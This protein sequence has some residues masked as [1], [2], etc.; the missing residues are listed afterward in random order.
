MPSLVQS[1]KKRNG[2]IATNKFKLR[3]CFNKALLKCL[4]ISIGLVILMLLVV[5][6]TLN[7]NEALVNVWETSSNKSKENFRNIKASFFDESM[8]E[9]E[10]VQGSLDSFT[11]NV[12]SDFFPNY[13]MNQHT[14]SPLASICEGLKY[15]N[16]FYYHVSDKFITEDLVKVRREVL[17]WGDKDITK[18]ITKN[19]KSGLTDKQIVD[20]FWFE[21]GASPVWLESENCYVA[22]SRIISAGL[23]RIHGT[24]SLVKAR[25]FDKNWN[26]IEGKRIPY[27]DVIIPENFEEKLAKF[28]IPMNAT[29]CQEFDKG[30]ELYENCIKESMAKYQSDQKKKE[31][32]IDKYFITYPRVLKFKFNFIDKFNGPEDPRVILKSDRSGEEPILIFN[33]DEG[34]GR[35]IYSLL[36]HRKRETLLEYKIEG[37][38]LKKVEKNWAPFF[39]PSYEKKNILS[40]N[41]IN[42]VYSFIPLEILQC[43]LDDGNCRKIFSGRA[44]GLDDNNKFN[45]LRGGTQF[46]PVPNIFPGHEGKNIW[47]AFS[48]VHVEN[49]GCGVHYYRPALTVLAETN[50]I[51]NFDIIA[52]D[53]DFGI[54]PYNWELEQE[55]CTKVNIISSNSIASWFIS[56]PD[57]ETNEI[58]DFLTLTT[59]E[60]DYYTRVITV[61]NLLKYISG[62][63]ERENFQSMSKVEDFSNT[64]LDLTR[65]CIIKYSKG[66]CKEFGKTHPFREPLKH[67]LP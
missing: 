55:H 64:V 42:F 36:P 24:M 13:I 16:D 1:L 62:F 54:E 39:H 56:E 46:V 67:T 28:D 10:F 66:K 15:R 22:Y 12:N 33:L 47:V 7:I 20:N 18:F 63:Y 5:F 50:Q 30:D 4:I 43:S 41:Y 61:K 32:I 27:K 14:T 58:T 51:Y 53:V 23:G 19:D 44:V 9:K 3:C 37:E 6:P 25:A 52:P 31:K 17:D 29:Q 21:F 48:K 35:K 8:L 60:A 59:S 45:G 34:K 11:H 2:V 65:R 40:N 26:E 57:P 38:T 49:C